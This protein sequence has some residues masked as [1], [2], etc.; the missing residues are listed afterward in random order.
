MLPD[1]ARLLILRPE[2]M[3]ALVALRRFHLLQ[4]STRPN[5][6]QALLRISGA[7]CTGSAQPVD[8]S[9]KRHARFLACFAK[10]MPVT[11][12]EVTFL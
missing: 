5:T 11:M 10:D 3:S 9:P 6:L 7:F 8:A 4:T 2:T 12:G 1:L